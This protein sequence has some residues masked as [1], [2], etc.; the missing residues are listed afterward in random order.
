MNRT[1]LIALINNLLADNNNQDISAADVRNVLLN[2]LNELVL[3]SSEGIPIAH[4][5]NIYYSVA[6]IDY[7]RKDSRTYPIFHIKKHSEERKDLMY[8]PEA[9][10]KTHQ[11]IQE[12][13]K[14]YKA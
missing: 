6:R 12:H 11:A 7:H 14:V 10:E 2:L 9:R 3:S 5:N 8:S 4:Q 13:I 1:E